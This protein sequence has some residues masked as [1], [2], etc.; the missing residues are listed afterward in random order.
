MDTDFMHKS[1]LQIDESSSSQLE[2]SGKTDEDDIEEPSSSSEGSRKSEQKRLASKIK[3]TDEK[4]DAAKVQ[5]EKLSKTIEN[6]QDLKKKLKDESSPEKGKSSSKS[7]SA[8]TAQI[9]E[10]EAELEALN[11]H[12]YELEAD[13]EDFLDE[14]WEFERRKS[15]KS[16]E[17]QEELDDNVDSSEESM[18]RSNSNRERLSTR[19]LE[20]EKEMEELEDE[21]EETIEASKN[22]KEAL[23]RKNTELQG[24]LEATIEKAK[25]EHFNLAVSYKEL[26]KKLQVTVD[27]YRKEQQAL[28]IHYIEK[29]RELKQTSAKARAEEKRLNAMITKLQK[30]IKSSQSVSKNQDESLFTRLSILLED[31]NVKIKEGASEDNRA[32]QK[33][34]AVNESQ[35]K[36]EVLVAKVSQ[37]KEEYS[38]SLSKTESLSET[39]VEI[40]GKLQASQEIIDRAEREAKDLNKSYAELEL[41]WNC[42]DEDHETSIWEAEQKMRDLMHTASLVT[43]E[44][45]RFKEQ[46]SVHKREIEKLR[47]ENKKLSSQNEILEEE[48]NTGRDNLVRRVAELEDEVRSISTENEIDMDLMAKQVK[49]VKQELETTK[50]QN[51]TYSS[52]IE[53]FEEEKKNYSELADVLKKLERELE[54][55][56]KES[57]SEKKWHLELKRRLFDTTMKSEAEKANLENRLYNLFVELGRM[58]KEREE[59]SKLPLRIAALEGELQVTLQESKTEK[60]LHSKLKNRLFNV[61]VKNEAEKANIERLLYKIKDELKWTTQELQSTQEKNRSLASELR[62]FEDEKDRLNRSDVAYIEDDLRST[63]EENDSIFTKMQSY[64]RGTSTNSMLSE[65]TPLKRGDSRSPLTPRGKGTESR[66]PNPSRK[67]SSSSPKTPRSKE[68][69]VTESTFFDED[70]LPSDADSDTAKSGSDVDSTLGVSSRKVPTEDSVSHHNSESTEKIANGHESGA[71]GSSMQPA[72]EANGTAHTARDSSDRSSSANA[73]TDEDTSAGETSGERPSTEEQNQ[74][75][76]Q[77][78]APLIARA[79]GI[80][81]QEVPLRVIQGIQD[82]MASRADEVD[83]DNS[84]VWEDFETVLEDVCHDLEEDTWFEIQEA[85]FVAWEEAEIEKMG[86]DLS[87]SYRSSSANDDHYNEQ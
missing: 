30:E 21:L 19:I 37:L 44:K 75:I 3:K 81:G 32:K 41:K 36:E 39:I 86:G 34:E 84:F 48:E 72:L 24:K 47:E 4:V 12:I 71:F 2:E 78:L 56:E 11:A 52:Q 54:L 29:E 82:R 6:L 28:A 10:S 67:N 35:R 8:L 25:R 73:E 20:L 1:D 40:E 46:C 63:L 50:R 22:Q 9:R 42:S 68:R 62:F 60:Q 69:T 83:F 26:E 53:C 5:R 15:A 66:S 74:E 65:L 80:L 49:N 7:T 55:R 61:I 79:D 59:Y 14:M 58:D 45:N 64:E 51:R 70:T 27:N 85:F 23:V 31:I 87:E 17:H 13:V 43:K 33:S 77:Y 76:V 16:Q 38:L 18:R 57:K